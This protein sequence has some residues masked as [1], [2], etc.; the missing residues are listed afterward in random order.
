MRTNV[1]Q[2][3][4]RARGVPLLNVKYTYAAGDPEGPDSLQP[5]LSLRL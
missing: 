3:A 1:E 2:F 4:I 5:L